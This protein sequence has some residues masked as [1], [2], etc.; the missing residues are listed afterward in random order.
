LDRKEAVALLRELME[1]NLAQPSLVSIEENQTGTFLIMK[2]DGNSQEL[3][4][5]VAGKNLTVEVDKENGY[6][7]IHEP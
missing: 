6:F 4:Q 5:F 2:D 1:N 3:R 7:I